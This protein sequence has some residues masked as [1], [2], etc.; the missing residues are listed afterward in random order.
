MVTVTGKPER[1]LD[2]LL[3]LR[4]TSTWCQA[5]VDLIKA[6]LQTA[7]ESQKIAA[8]VYEG[9]VKFSLMNAYGRPTYTI[10]HV[11]GRQMRVA[12]TGMST[13]EV[14]SKRKRGG[15]SSHHC[16]GDEFRDRMQKFIGDG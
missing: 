14:Y 8:F 13:I 6:T 10:H 11:D 9:D 12:F 1:S 4:C 7:L 2:E 5:N 3:H 16:R 15:R